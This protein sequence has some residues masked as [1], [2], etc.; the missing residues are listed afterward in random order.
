MGEPLA[1]GQVFAR[2][3]RDARQNQG[4]TQQELVQRLAELGLR[5]D[6]STLNKLESG[7][8]GVRVSLDKVFAL[9]AALEIQPIHLLLP[10]EDEQP[11]AVTPTTVVPARLARAWVRGQVALPG[12]SVTWAEL[13]E[14]ELEQL[15]W[16][17]LTR[18]W[19]PLQAALMADE[20]KEEVR[21]IVKAIR[22]PEEDQ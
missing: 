7:R 20:L 14:S 12:R 18:G 8:E 19:S 9:A 10:L 17:A 5:M 22:N 4:L 16:R 21:E 13:P 3:V 11:V 2:R 15:V 6:R 1:P